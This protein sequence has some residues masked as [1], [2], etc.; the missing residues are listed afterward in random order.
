MNFALGSEFGDAGSTGFDR[1]RSLFLQGSKR[2][3][4]GSILQNRS[5]SSGSY[6]RGGQ[7]RWDTRSSGSSDKDADVQSDLD[8]VGQGLFNFSN[9]C[10]VICKNVLTFQEFCMPQLQVDWKRL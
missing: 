6:V 8:S 5:E 1:P 3:E 7:G 2:G 4:Y 9:D 10:C